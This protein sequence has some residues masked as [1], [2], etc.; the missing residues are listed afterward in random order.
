M[1]GE[2]KEKTSKK[3]IN[4]ILFNARSANNKISELRSL[5]FTEK[6]DLICITETWF[7]DKISDG[8]VCADTKYSI[9][10][11]DRVARHGG[12]V[13]VLYRTDLKLFEIDNTV[14]E[15]LVC[16]LYD[17]SKCKYR[18][19]VCYRPPHYDMDSAISICS[20]IENY[21]DGKSRNIIV[22]D[23]NL[24]SLASNKKLDAISEIFDITTQNKCM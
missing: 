23:F 17:S 2:K 22:G 6:F 12:G 18:L 14:Q 16:D 8:I 24:P 13:A 21:I 11:K 19:I 20:N 1:Q 7:N 3:F 4:C 10:R 9:L 15:S 5:L